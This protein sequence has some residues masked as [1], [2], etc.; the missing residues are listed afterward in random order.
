MPGTA[1]KKKIPYTSRSSTMYSREQ[2]TR[3]K[4][5][6]VHW[7]LGSRPWRNQHMAL[8]GLVTFCS[9]FTAGKPLLSNTSAEP[10]VYLCDSGY[11]CQLPAAGL[12]L[13]PPELSS[14]C[15]PAHRPTEG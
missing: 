12:D 3:S 11:R 9:A 4:G 15:P 2:E 5:D 10:A 1:I 14:F 8:V 13:L 6:S 7:V